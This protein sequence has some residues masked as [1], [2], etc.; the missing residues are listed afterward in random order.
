MARE[1]VVIYTDGACSGNQE[2]TNVGGWGAVLTYGDNKNLEIWG[3]EKNTTNNRMEM[4]ACI[5]ALEHL[6]RDGIEVEIFS[7]SAY[8]VNCFRQRWYAKWQRNGWKN[9][10]KEPVENKDLWIRLLELVDRH[11]VTFYKV[12]GHSGIELNELADKL[13]NRGIES[14]R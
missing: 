2:A 1:K 13:A 10:K 11:R 3:G 5:Q 9:S 4:T 12:K 6:K 8:I 14:M 7:D